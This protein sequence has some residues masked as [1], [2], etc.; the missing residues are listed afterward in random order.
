[1]ILIVGVSFGCYRIIYKNNND[2]NQSKL[3]DSNNITTKNNQ[4][5]KDGCVVCDS[6]G[7]ICCPSK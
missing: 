4:T 3:N 5:V 2:N 6:E 7:G 1:M